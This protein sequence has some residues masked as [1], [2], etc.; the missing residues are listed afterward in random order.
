MGVTEAL[1]CNCRLYL[2]APVAQKAPDLRV[3]SCHVRICG[4]SPVISTRGVPLP[5]V[6]PALGRATVPPS[7]VKHNLLCNAKG[8]T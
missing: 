3:A 6:R 5:G 4:P 1:V 7:R 2:Q 8:L